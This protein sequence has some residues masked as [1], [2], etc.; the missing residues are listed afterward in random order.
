[1]PGF[2]IDLNKRLGAREDLHT[3]STPYG[4]TVKKGWQTNHYMVQTEK[5]WLIFDYGVDAHVTVVK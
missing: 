3:Y 2:E 1:M 4:R 5:G